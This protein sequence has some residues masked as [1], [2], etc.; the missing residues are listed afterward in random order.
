MASHK[1]AAKRARQSIKRTLRNARI[2]GRMKT[3][4]RVF[5][6]ALASGDR[7]VAEKALKRATRELRRAA[8]DGVVHARNASRRVSRL[9]LALNK[10]P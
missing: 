3:A 1:S 5:R 6:E 2:R 7:A 4:I 10:V 9:V 8:S